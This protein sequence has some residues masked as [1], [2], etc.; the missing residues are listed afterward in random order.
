[1]GISVRA[2]PIAIV[3]I[4]GWGIALVTI[5]SVIWVGIIAY[6]DHQMVTLSN[7]SD[8]IG[9]HVKDGEGNLLGRI[10]DLVFHWRRDG[11]TEY[12]VLSLGG[13]F[14]E[15]AHVAVPWE[16][17]TPNTKKNHFV[18]NMNEVQL[19]NMPEFVWYR[20]D[21]RSFAAVRGV[22]RSTAEASAIATKGNLKSVASVAEAGTFDRAHAMEQTFLR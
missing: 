12:A 8:V 4:V 11:Y 13:F 5:V 20:V 22:D 9:T 10:Q 7:I 1:M 3:G 16:A 15:E 19:E 2:R 14:G 6:A 17:L 21:D 18:L